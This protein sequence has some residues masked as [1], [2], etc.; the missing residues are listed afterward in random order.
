MALLT[1]ANVNAGYGKKTVIRDVGLTVQEGEIVA[2]IGPNGAGKSTALKAILGL[3]NYADGKI[4]FGGKDLS[5]LTTADRISL[6]MSF[7]AQ[8]N[9]VFAELTVE[10]NLRLAANA[11]KGGND[12]KS[13]QD[14]IQMFPGL[15]NRPRQKAGTLSGGEQQMVAIARAFLQHPRLLILDEPSLG[16]APGLASAVLGQISEIAGKVGVAVLIVEQKVRRV[17]QIANRVYALRLGRVAYT[18]EARILA[19]DAVTLRGLFL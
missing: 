16:L 6:G 12:D 8:G 3:L 7:C 13:L 4:E 5:G 2:L 18:G 10:E 9:R 19:E 14:V 17:L 11:V 15:R 1:V